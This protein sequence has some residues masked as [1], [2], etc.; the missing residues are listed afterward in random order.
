MSLQIECKGIHYTYDITPT[1]RNLFNVHFK[2]GKS[3]SYSKLRH[4][5]HYLV[6]TFFEQYIMYDDSD[7]KVFI[8][9][10]R[11]ILG[12]SMFNKKASISL[13]YM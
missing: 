6:N 11:R 10:V 9:L 2:I 4:K 8:D 12:I 1:S 3:Y 7:E 13:S 5:Y